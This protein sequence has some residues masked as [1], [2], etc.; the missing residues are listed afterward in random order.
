[1]A[2]PP[3]CT[4]PAGLLPASYSSLVSLTELYVAGNDLSGTLP[5]GTWSSSLSNLTVLDVRDNCRYGPAGLPPLLGPAT[6]WR[7]RTPSAGGAPTGR[8][9]PT[10][11]E[12]GHAAAPYSEL[13]GVAQLR[14]EWQSCQAG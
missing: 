4:A 3:A 2:A 9:W 10:Q 7:L 14:G 6:G 13:N 1:M 8:Q 11:G 5:D 12:S